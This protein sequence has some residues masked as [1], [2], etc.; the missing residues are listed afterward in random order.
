MQD[1]PVLTA[2][3]INDELLWPVFEL[4]RRHVLA[5][6]PPFILVMAGAIAITI[7]VWQGLWITGLQRPAFWGFFIVNFVFW[8]GVSHAGTM[9]SSILRLTQAEWKRPITRAAEVMTVF[10]LVT[11]LIH[12]VIHA[13]RPWRI[14]YWL[15]PYDFTRGIWPDV[16]S[17]LVWDPVA[18]TTYLTGSILFVFTA[19]I[20]DFAIIRDQSTGMRR[21][22][23]RNVGHGLARHPAA[24]AIA[25]HLRHPDV[26][27]DSPCLR[28][29][30]QHRVVGLR[31]V[32]GACMACDGLRAV[33]RHWSG[34]LRRVHG[35]DID[36]VN[37]LDLQAGELHLGR[38]L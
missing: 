4:R 25:G 12:P 33:L 7:L 14:I 34:P 19:L 35:A 2:S 20:P 17:P 16:R 31:G 29:R 18:I 3:Q 1:R 24:V 27:P 10:A 11:S 32:R 22:Y 38:P 30:P 28:F 21:T 9:I 13:G 37:A 15:L 23:L 8:I 5:F 6:L 26:R 36:G